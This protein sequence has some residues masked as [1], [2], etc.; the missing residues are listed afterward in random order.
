MD[1]AT[2]RRMELEEY[3]ETQLNETYVGT[4]SQQDVKDEEIVVL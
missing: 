3:Q 4:R 2:T 1:E